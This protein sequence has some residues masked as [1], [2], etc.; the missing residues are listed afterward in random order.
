[1]NRLLLAAALALLALV[2]VPAAQ[3]SDAF[4]FENET[5]MVFT[6]NDMD[7]LESEC[8]YGATGVFVAGPS[9][10]EDGSVRSEAGLGC[11]EFFGA[12]LAFKQRYGGSWEQ[13]EGPVFFWEGGVGAFGFQADDPLVG[14]SSV[15]CAAN[16]PGW[17]EGNG[18]RPIEAFMT[19]EVDG[20]T[21]TVEWLPG[22]DAGDVATGSAAGSAAAGHVR[23]VDS[24]AE[25][26]GGKARVRVQVFG[27]GGAQRRCTVVLR[28]KAGEAIGRASRELKVGDKARTIAVPLAPFARQALRVGHDLRAGA[29]LSIDSVGGSGDN[30]SQ[31]VLSRR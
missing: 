11:R 15:D 29:V 9:G 19:A 22:I 12:N 31:L 13:S 18:F 7:S 28:G 30:T 2:V 20:N 23:F 4:Y 25:V 8:W 5:G 3:A 10:S 1:M 14:F 24:R 27:R 6:P 21:C 17:E 26:R 16:G